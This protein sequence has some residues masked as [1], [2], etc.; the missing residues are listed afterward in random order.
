MAP[1]NEGTKKILT[2]EARRPSKPR[3]EFDPGITDLEPEVPLD[4]DV[5]KFLHNFKDSQ[6]RVCWRSFRDD[7]QTSESWVGGP[8]HLWPHG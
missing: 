7:G 4:L 2:D 1:G 5:D 3:S 6:E 8:R